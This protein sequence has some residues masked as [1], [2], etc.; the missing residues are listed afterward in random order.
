MPTKYKGID[1]NN[2][3][4]II[5][6]TVG[7]AN[8][9]T[10]LNQKNVIIGALRYCQIHKGLEIYAFNAQSFVMVWKI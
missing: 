1:I 5:I 4:F 6:T 2:A 7:W 3:Y 10:K 8:I 9:F